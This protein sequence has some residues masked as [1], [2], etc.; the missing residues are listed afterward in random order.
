VA[1]LGQIWNS[2]VSEAKVPLPG[3]IYTSPLTRCLETTDAMFRE[4]FREN[5]TEFR[6]NIN[7]TLRGR[8]SYHTFNRRSNRSQISS[9]FP[10]FNLP[11]LS[12]EDSLWTPGGGE[13]A[14]ALE[15][16]VQK[17]LEDIFS[18]DSSQFVALTT[19]SYLIL[20]LLAVLGMK[21]FRVREG[22]SIAILVKGVKLE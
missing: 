1:E 3:T 22:S 19:H 10:D 7:E 5:A 2:L 9:N 11:S 16:M 14:G 21:V 18:H 15:E 4:V 13:A 20:A 8:V 6:P 12:E 17:A